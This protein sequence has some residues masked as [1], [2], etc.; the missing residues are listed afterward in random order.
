MRVRVSAI[1]DEFGDPIGAVVIGADLRETL[2]LEK[3]ISERM[4]AEEILREKNL[5]MEK[6]LRNAQRIQ[7]A[8]LPGTAPRHDRVK[9]DFR[10][11][12]A[13]EIGGDYFS[14]TE[15]PSGELGVFIC[16]V[17]G[18]G[19]SAALFLSLVKFEF[20]RVCR[21]CGDRPRVF[22]E[23]LN[24]DLMVSMQNYFLTAVFGIFS[25]AENG[26]GAV[27]TFA[28]AGH[29]EPLLQ[30]GD[31]GEVTSLSCRGTVVGQF[32]NACYEQEQV[33]L[34]K[35]DR[36]YLYTDGIIESRDFE[37]NCF[38]TEG[39]VNALRKMKGSPLSAALNTIIGEMSLF[40][41]T[42]TVEDDIVLIGF[43]IL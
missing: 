8:L 21:S 40:R 34:G 42:D 22:M 4:R 10:N 19:V 11:S 20:D 16:D 3:E 27:F 33:V 31:T 29:P 39:I 24:R 41:G 18:H 43:E 13:T 6:D 37:K 28:R 1:E 35:G 12:T 2:L 30:H 9:I 14:F 23:E 5:A 25:F 36:I 32:R 26:D 17:S 38:G 15:F 7:K